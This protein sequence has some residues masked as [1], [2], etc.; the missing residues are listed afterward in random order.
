[1]AH[2]IISKSSGISHICVHNLRG[3]NQ[4]FISKTVLSR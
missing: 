2:A 4:L 1:L 3:K